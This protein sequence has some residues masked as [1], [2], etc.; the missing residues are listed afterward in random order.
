MINLRLAVLITMI[1]ILITMIIINIMIIMMINLR[2]ARLPAV[3]GA[4][5]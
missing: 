5:L 1:I 2:L 4:R 3:L